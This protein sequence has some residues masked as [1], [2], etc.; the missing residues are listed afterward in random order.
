MDFPGLGFPCLVALLPLPTA[1]LPLP[2]SVV[3]IG[4]EL[5][6]WHQPVR[7]ILNEHVLVPCSRAC[8]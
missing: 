2:T 4:M 6:G 7:S 5:T 3:S 1:L 8:L